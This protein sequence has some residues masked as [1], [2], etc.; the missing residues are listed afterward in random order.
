MPGLVPRRL[1]A[2]VVVGALVAG[3]CGGRA[4][5]PRTTGPSGPVTVLAAASLTEAFG[6]V[7]VALQ[8]R[9]PGLRVTYSFGGS[10]ALVRQIEQGAP[11]DVFASADT[12]TMQRLVD[13][14]LVEAPRTFAEN[15][16]E[17]VVGRGNPKHVAGL[18]DLGRADLRVVLADPSVPVGSYSRQA[19]DRAGVTAHPRSLELDVKA[20]LA[21]VLAGEA[22]AAIVYQSD[23]AAAGASVTGVVVPAGEN[24][25]AEYPIAIVKRTT[26][27]RAAE[28]FVDEVLGGPGR[29]A[30][31]GRGFTPP[32]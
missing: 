29:E 26:N 23:V 27:R 13:E 15:R 17:I 25:V 8:A 24:V 2:I 9:S 12:K 21:K 14:G 32:G 22:D 6:D 7:R 28:A 16:L 18:R 10:Q 11:A 30:L 20:V 4:H 19:L 1:L 3:A 31:Q 5:P